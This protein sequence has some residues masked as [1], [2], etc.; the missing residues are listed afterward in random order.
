MMRPQ[1]DGV[2]G[3]Q[4]L[5]VAVIMCKNQIRTADKVY[6]IPFLSQPVLLI[7]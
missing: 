4:V 3:Y 2:D 7:Q 6:C 5:K 1:N